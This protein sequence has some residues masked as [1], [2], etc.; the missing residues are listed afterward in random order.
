MVV[1]FSIAPVGAGE[2]LSTYVAKMFRIIHESGLPYE[3]HAMGT[4]I[5][6]DWDEV[7]ALINACRKRILERV[8]RVSIVIKI[9][10]RKGITD[11]LARKV[12]SAKEEMK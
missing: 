4:N 9:D 11:G 12:S 10:D 3:H 7:T 6:G 2:S 1:D 5:E 8:N